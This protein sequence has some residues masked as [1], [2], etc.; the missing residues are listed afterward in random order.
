MSDDNECNVDVDW[1]YELSSRDKRI[2]EL[3]MKVNDSRVYPSYEQPK[4]SLPVLKPVVNNDRMPKS[5]LPVLKPVVNTDEQYTIEVKT[6]SCCSCR[7]G[8]STCGITGIIF[9]PI[10]ILMVLAANAGAIYGIVKLFQ[11]ADSFDDKPCDRLDYFNKVNAS[12]SYEEYHRMADR[13]SS[14][15]SLGWGKAFSVIGEI[16]FFVGSGFG[17]FGLGAWTCFA[18]CAVTD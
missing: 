3:E 7:P 13:C 5:S 14:S 16:I 18:C 11:N 10:C 17:I 6:S 8:Y 12:V 9:G 15:L 2:A 1:E 4:S